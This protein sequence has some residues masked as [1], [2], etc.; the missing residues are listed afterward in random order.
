MTSNTDSSYPPVWLVALATTQT[1]TYMEVLR[2][3][4]G[5]SYLRLQ[6]VSV[7]VVKPNLGV[8]TVGEAVAGDPVLLVSPPPRHNAVD[9][10]GRTQVHLQPLVI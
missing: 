1:W 5:V 10:G 8:V 2:L 4:S 6:V 9:Q 7:L 3:C